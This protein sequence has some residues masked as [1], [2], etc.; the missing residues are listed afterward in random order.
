MTGKISSLRTDSAQLDIFVQRFR[1]IAEEM[2]Y[3]LQRTG[4]TAF[5]NE[6]ADLGVALVT[7]EGEIFGY[8][9]SIGITM[10]ANLNFKKVIGSFERFEQGDILI[11]NDPYSSGGLSSHLPDISLLSPI[12]HDGELVCFAYSYVH[13]TDVG[14]RVAGSL[15]P[16]SYEIYQEGIRIPPSYLYRA[17]AL[18][19][20]L[21]DL[22]LCNCRVPHDNWGDLK[23]MVTALRV[24]DQRVQESVDKYGRDGFVDAMYD[25]LQYSEMRAR[26]VIRDIPDGT[27]HF[28]DYL[29]DDVVSDIPIKFCVALTIQGDEIELDFTGSDSQLRTAFNIYSDGAAHPWLVYT[30]MFVLL[31]IDR[32]IPVNAGLMRSV[33]VISQPGSVVN[34]TAPAAVGLRTTTGVRVQDTIRGAL[35]QA[36]PG[37]IPAAGAGYIAPIVFTEPDLVKGG[38]KVNVLEPMVGGTGAHEDGDGLNARDVVDIANLRNSPIEI[39]ENVSGV[40]ILKY[41]LRPDSGGAGKFRGGLGI[42]F[43][44]EVL[45]HDCLVTARGQERH[46]FRPWGLMGGKCGERA[47]VFIKRAGRSE[48][49]P[50]DKIDSLQVDCG[51]V[52]RILT[53]GG[54][55][56]GHSHERDPEH[57]LQDLLNGLISKQ[58]ARALY[59][60]VIEDG[61]IDQAAT[62]QLR[63]D[64][65]PSRQPEMFCFGPERDAYESV[66]TEEAWAR[67][68]QKVFSLPVPLRASMRTRLWTAANALGEERGGPLSAADVDLC[69]TETVPAGI[70]YHVATQGDESLAH[71]GISKA[72]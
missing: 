46:R 72:S 69:W 40:R 39:V 60:V 32:D 58:A 52:L 3:S 7:P 19:K 16:S 37:A 68:I 27:Y 29:D 49:E 17:G 36:F 18:N 6:T 64:T 11:C 25:V 21:I 20:E 70:A 43:E 9:H 26:A 59:S 35:A 67:L 50:L 5:V 61:V 23:A 10:F 38:L 44:F 4:H 30:I 48:F 45:E 14:G 66:W 41:A 13:S 65:M 8:P 47:A 31:T 2:G 34:C 51:D 55:G 63:H 15:S 33:S 28:A 56:Y 71:H 57:V 54:G 1:S 62:A 22:I 53:P 12:F 42:I 24:A